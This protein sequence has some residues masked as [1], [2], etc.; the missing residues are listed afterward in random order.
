MKVNLVKMLRGRSIRWQAVM[1]ETSIVGVFHFLVN[2]HD[3]RQAF[4][5]GVLLFSEKKRSLAGRMQLWHQCQ[6]FCFTR[7]PMRIPGIQSHSL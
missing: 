1:S 4:S 7:Q 2:R 6:E 5:G 3:P